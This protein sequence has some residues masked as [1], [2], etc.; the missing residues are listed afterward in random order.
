M[1][2]INYNFSDIERGYDS[3]SEPIKN[4]SLQTSSLRD[5]M[6]FEL[7]KSQKLSDIQATK[8]ANIS[9]RMMDIDEANRKINAA[10]NSAEV[11]TANEKSKYLTNLEYQDRMLDSQALNRIFSNVINP[12]GQQFSQQGRTA[13][14]MQG[15]AEYESDMDAAQQHALRQMQVSIP[16]N[17]KTAWNKLTAAEKNSYNNDIATYLLEKDPTKYASIMNTVNNTLKL[18]RR[19]A[20]ANYRDYIG[21]NLSMRSRQ[22]VPGSITQEA[23]GGKISTSK[24]MRDAQE[25]I[26]I[27]GDKEAKRAAQKLSDHLMRML[28]QLIK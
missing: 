28:A 26:A 18:A 1:D 21:P 9:K 4:A 2:K 15:Q 23:K 25:Q 20:T 17:I 27:N 13:W 22:W 3:A 5:A 7:S 8:S 10:N 24:N 14:Q 12:L 19:N 16:E 6:A 11:A